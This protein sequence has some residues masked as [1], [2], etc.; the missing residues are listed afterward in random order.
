MKA[1]RAALL[2]LALAGAVSVDLA[3]HEALAKGD[4]G[5]DGGGGGGGGGGGS[6]SG[7]GGDSGSS[8]SGS[9]GSGSDSSGSG[10]SGSSGDDSGSHSGSDDSGSGE[11]SASDD[12]GGAAGARGGRDE[13]SGELV[14][15]GRGELP[16]RAQDLGYVVLERR[17]LAHLDLVVTRVR[18]PRG[19]DLATA[20]RRIEDLAPGL[21]ADANAL[22]RPSG[23]VEL[24]PP[25]FARRLIGWQGRAGTC[26]GDL[27][28]GLIDGRVDPGAPALAGAR[29]DRRGF[30]DGT[31]ASAHGTFVAT[32]L[33]GQGGEAGEGL[34]PS[35]RLLAAEVF[36][37]T[38]DGP[39]ATASAIAEALDWQVGA[40]AR[41]IN[42]SFAG[43]DNRLTALAVARAA[44][45][46]AVL[47]AAAGNAGPGAPPAFPAAYP[48]VIAVTAVDH[49]LAP[50]PK[51]NRGPY[52][53]FA[54]PGVRVPVMSAQGAVQL[55][56]GTSF[57]T[58]FVTAAAGALVA[59]GTKPGEVAS[60]LAARARPLGGGRN[61]DTGWGLVQAAPP[62]P[63]S[64]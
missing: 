4:G 9:S 10:S 55:V 28:I 8:G 59:S 20:R 33:V 60:S 39:G 12:S 54:A 40:G 15:V 32:L 29:L 13:V 47:V 5:G 17:A 43:H 34:L 61:A 14:L 21:L 45:R 6:G 7:H 26:A 38:R 44:E 1:F 22:Y 53:A 50:W 11:D 46:G 52:V 30:V 63:V 27:G 48:E 16:R 58:P 3:A 23:E 42:M 41:V 37:A 56:T 35:A 2:C 62:C 49:H 31:T 57:A 18:V 36:G 64:E 51:A 25:G 24:P 19:T